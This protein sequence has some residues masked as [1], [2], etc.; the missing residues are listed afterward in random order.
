MLDRLLPQRLDNGYRGHKLAPWL[1]GVVV[2]VK[3]AQS[4]AIIFAGYSTA[5]DADGI[6]LDSYPAAAAATMVSVL[7]QGSLWRLIFCLLGVVV[8]LRYRSAVPLILALLVLN[9]LAGQ[10]MFHFVPLVRLGTPPGPLVNLVLFSLMIVGLGLSVW[11]ESGATDR[12]SLH[13]S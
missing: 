3:S 1:F 12:D 9:Y 4:L 11:T 6:P 2:A 7:A 5:R 10:V 13:S 8:L